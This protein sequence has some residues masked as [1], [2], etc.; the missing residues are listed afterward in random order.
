MSIEEGYCSKQADKFQTYYN[1]TRQAELIA[2][3]YPKCLKRLLKLP[4]VN[5]LYD[6]KKFLMTRAYLLDLKDILDRHNPTVANQECKFIYHGTN[7]LYERQPCLEIV[8][9]FETLACAR[10]AKD[11]TRIP[12]PNLA[13]DVLFIR[14]GFIY[15][16]LCQK[17]QEQELAV[18]RQLK[19]SLTALDYILSLDLSL[20]P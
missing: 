15:S 2:A 17:I 4:K 12:I 5:R 1:S 19:G 14:R 6:L 9:T 16:E 20:Q 18:S 11:V 7:Q 13:E 8:L 10:R 3:S